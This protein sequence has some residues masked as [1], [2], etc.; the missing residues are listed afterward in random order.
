MAKTYTLVAKIT[1]P[2]SG[3]TYEIKKDETGNLSCN[4]MAWIYDAKREG[5]HRK[6]K[7][8]LNYL[9]VPTTETPKKR[10]KTPLESTETEKTALDT[11]PDFKLAPAKLK[12][13]LKNK[14]FATALKDLKNSL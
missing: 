10:V 8:I 6:C 1:S 4:C 12:K 14:E 9:G 13:I 2:V 11:K 7:H 3:K 5:I